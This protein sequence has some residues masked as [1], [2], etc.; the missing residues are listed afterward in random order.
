MEEPR[1]RVISGEADRDIIIGTSN[2]DYITP[3]RVHVVVG[4]ATGAPDH[5]KGVAV[6]MEWVL[7]NG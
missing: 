1:S 4:A 2:V 5:T 7:Y 6:E 3:D